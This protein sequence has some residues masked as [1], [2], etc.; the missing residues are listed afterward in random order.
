MQ[1]EL[2]GSRKEGGGQAVAKN[3]SASEATILAQALLSWGML[4]IRPEAPP[5]SSCVV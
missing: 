3:Q 1:G 2:S 4:V 5:S